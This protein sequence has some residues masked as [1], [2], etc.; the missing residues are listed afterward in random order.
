MPKNKQRKAPRKNAGEK[1]LAFDE[2]IQSR[3]RMNPDK[4]AKNH[5]EHKGGPLG[6]ANRLGNLVMHAAHPKADIK[7]RDGAAQYKDDFGGWTKYAANRALQAGA[8]TGAGATLYGLS[9]GLGEAIEALSD[10]PVFGTPGDQQESG[11]LP[12][13]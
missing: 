11:Q 12:L 7:I 3:L 8:L 10:V 2:A 6:A 13:A 1:L 9:Q 4:W 5:A